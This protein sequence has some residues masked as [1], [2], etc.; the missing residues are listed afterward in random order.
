MSDRSVSFAAGSYRQPDG[1]SEK[2]EDPYLD[3]GEGR[4]RLHQDVRWG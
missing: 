3:D 4:T 2:V 1:V